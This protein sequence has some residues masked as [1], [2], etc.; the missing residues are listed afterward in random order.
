MNE[1]EDVLGE[2]PTD[3][4]IVEAVHGMAAAR[5]LASRLD[6]ETAAVLEGPY[7]RALG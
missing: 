4:A 6:D 2:V 3:R 5:L 7:W 1:V